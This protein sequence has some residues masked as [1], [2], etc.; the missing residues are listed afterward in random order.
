MKRIAG[1]LAVLLASLLL[2][3]PPGLAVTGVTGTANADNTIV[4][5]V[6][7]ST[8]VKIGIDLAKSVNTSIIEATGKLITAQVGST[9]VG[10]IA[11]RTS[12]T[13]SKGTS[14][15]PSTT[16]S[17]P[18]VVS[19]TVAS[20]SV[21]TDIASDHV[22]SAVDFTAGTLNLLDGFA[23]LATTSTDTLSRV[24]GN[25]STVTREVSIGDADVL[26]L[27]ELLDRLGVD[28]LAL[29]CEAVEAAGAA[30]LVDTDQACESLADV[31]AK[32]TDGQGAIEAAKTALGPIDTLVSAV[33][34]LGNSVCEAAKVAIDSQ[35]DALLAVDSTADTCAT[36]GESLD[37]TA[38]GL[39]AL[40]AA[41]EADP[42]IGPLVDTTALEGT[43]LAAVTAAKPALDTACDALSD[44][45]DL[46]LDM[47]LLSLDGL[48]LSLEAVAKPSPVAKVAGAI[49]SLKIGNLAP[50]PVTDLVSTAATLAGAV[51][52]VKT[53]L[54]GVL[55][56]LGLG[57]PTP[58]LDLL[59][60]ATDKGKE[61][62]GTYFAEASMTAVH[63]RVPP[64]TLTIPASLPL[65]VLAGSS[66]FGTTAAPRGGA[67]RAAS[68]LSTPDV[69][70]DAGVFSGDA[71]W[72]GGPTL[73]ATGVPG[74]PG[75]GLVLSGIAALA[76]AGILRR[77]VRLR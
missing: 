19:V 23:T 51:D 22:S 1:F 77:F 61:S 49:G 8:T 31:T 30:A 75:A 25:S 66:G 9:T 76:G 58:E 46:L 34:C 42:V 18:G 41:I 12:R 4:S 45:L 60:T 35:I 74:A 2:V 16:V 72:R 47:S 68:T 50:V 48:D 7:G 65:G 43:T 13:P 11:E 64:A 3:A 14:A 54:G 71:T 29:A 24:D 6:V 67:V 5:V 20:G 59:K 53:T 62:D 15:L 21:T 33:D 52:T 56:A 39:T 55:S 57:L 70:V 73:P 10:S 69:V 32:V 28:P 44:I 40:I 17:V 63:V 36:L 37:G 27:R 26:S 38:S